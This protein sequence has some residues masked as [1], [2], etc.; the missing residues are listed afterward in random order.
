MI[1]EAHIEGVIKYPTLVTV[2]DEEGVESQVND[3]AG[4]EYTRTFEA[5]SHAEAKAV[6]KKGISEQVADRSA[7]G[8]EGT[9]TAYTVAKTLLLDKA[10]F[11]VM[12]EVS[13]NIIV[14]F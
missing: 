13:E 10:P 5:S 6:F 14:D 2:I 7:V 12:V 1:Y 3:T 9:V 8:F 11:S 4:I